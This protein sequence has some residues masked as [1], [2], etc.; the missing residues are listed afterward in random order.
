MKIESNII[1]NKYKQEFNFI[2]KLYLKEIFPHAW[3]FY[4]RKSR[5]RESF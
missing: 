4:G 2:S 3:I 5:E 1:E